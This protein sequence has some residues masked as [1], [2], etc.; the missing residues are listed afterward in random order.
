MKKVISFSGVFHDYNE[1][2]EIGRYLITAL[3][4]AP[5]NLKYH[6]VQ[7][8]GTVLG[9][10]VTFPG[11]YQSSYAFAIDDAMVMID[12]VPNID[13][14]RIPHI[15]HDDSDSDRDDDDYYDA[16][17]KYVRDRMKLIVDTH[18]GCYCKT[19][20]ICGCGCDPLH[21]GW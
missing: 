5:K 16:M 8:D 10:D 12:G 14:K 11:M 19:Q 9:V 15:D 7:N 4:K 2:G 18:W 17:L 1:T 6:Q 20:R 13:V 21:D 3:I